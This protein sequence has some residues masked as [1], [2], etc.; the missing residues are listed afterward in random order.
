MS[1][2][3]TVLENNNRIFGRS[4]SDEKI[5]NDASKLK[6]IQ[7][8]ILEGKTDNESGWEKMKRILNNYYE[9]GNILN[10]IF[11]AYNYSAVDED[12]I[13]EYK[14]NPVNPADTF[15]KSIEKVRIEA[16]NRADTITDEAKLPELKEILK[17][18]K[19]E[20]S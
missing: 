6:N 5:E 2:F 13:R 17:L 20:S 14:Q 11:S 19:M 3:K 9:P 1:N 16:F 7:R 4:K 10:N 18:R 12:F 15:L 8:K